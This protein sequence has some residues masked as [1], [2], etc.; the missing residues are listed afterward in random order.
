MSSN[1]EI[2]QAFFDKCEAGEGW[3][4]VKSYCTPDAT[5][6]G[7]GGVFHP[8]AAPEPNLGGTL[9][10]YVNW[11][12]MLYHDLTP[13]CY[14]TEVS[15]AYDSETRTALFCGVFNGTHSKTPEGAPLPPPTNKTTSSDYVYSIHFNADGKIDKMVKIWNSEWA[16]KDFGWA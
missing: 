13:G 15:K 11:M 5:F 10:N 6:R 1:L 12:K 3:D 14:L 4:A 9:E 2:A 8:P 7:Q 16:A